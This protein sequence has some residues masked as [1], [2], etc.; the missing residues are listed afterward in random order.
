MRAT[1]AVMEGTV[2]KESRIKSRSAKYLDQNKEM[3]VVNPSIK[4][5]Q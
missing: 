3:M 5:C 1:I 2:S 4:F